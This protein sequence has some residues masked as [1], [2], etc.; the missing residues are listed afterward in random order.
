MNILS[1]Y[2]ADKFYRY[3]DIELGGTKTVHLTKIGTTNDNT[4]DN[5]TEQAN[6]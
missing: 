2:T 6:K 1:S 5:L 3:F 4:T